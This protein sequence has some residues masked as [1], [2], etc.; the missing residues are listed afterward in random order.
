MA[1][2]GELDRANLLNRGL[3]MVP[4]RR[5]DALSRWDIQRTK[6]DSVRTFFKAAPGNVPTQTAFSQD[7]RFEELDTDRTAGCIRDSEHAFSKDGGLA[8]LFG[9]LALDGYIVKTAGV[10]DSILKFEGPR[11][12]PESRDAAVEGILGGKV[13]AGDVVVVRYEGRAADRACKEM[14]YPDQLSKIEGP[15]EA[16]RV[17]HR[18]ALL[19]WVVGAVDRPDVAGSSRRRPPLASLKMAISSRS[20]FP[21]V[22]SASLL[23]MRLSHNAGKQCSPAGRMPWKPAEAEPQRFQWRS[24]PTRPSPRAPPTARCAS[25]PNKDYLAALKFK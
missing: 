5:D 11:T 25:F 19:R 18:R 1:I 24:R 13:K 3:P 10:D 17:N 20:I 7:K 2:L 4:A 14:L 23:M 8:V 22:Q 16:V 15:R 12:L 21:R 6:S 9:N